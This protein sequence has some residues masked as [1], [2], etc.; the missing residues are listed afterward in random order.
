MAQLET[1]S[2]KKALPKYLSLEESLELIQSINPDED[3]RDYCILTLFLNCGMRLSELV[4]LDLADIKQ[5][6]IKVTGKGNK[7]RVIYLNDAC[8]DAL[9]RYLA[10]RGKIPHANAT[11]ALFPSNQGRRISPRRV[12]QIVAE[13]LK[14]AGLGGMGYSTH[15]LRHTA[16]TLMYQYGKVDIRLLKEILG[17]VSVA[18]TEIYTHVSSEQM[19]NAVG[20]SPLAKVTYKTNKTKDMKESIIQT[21]KDDALSG[22]KK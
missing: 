6:T 2:I 11:S 7:E 1:P 4:G 15:K 13:S 12:Q 17:H 21:D 5:D 10:V 14:K 20:Q 8:K 9:E 3:A 16:A 19:K 22:Q 18:T